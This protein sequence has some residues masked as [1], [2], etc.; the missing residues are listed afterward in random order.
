[1]LTLLIVGVVNDVVRV[2]AVEPDNVVPVL[3]TAVLTADGD[4][5]VNVVGAVVLSV[6][7]KTRHTEIYYSPHSNT[8]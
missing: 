3:V 8:H 6:K 5:V 2:V 1:M 7:Q 4:S